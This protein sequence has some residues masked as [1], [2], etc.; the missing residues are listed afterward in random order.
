MNKLNEWIEHLNKCSETICL[1][2]KMIGTTTWPMLSSSTTTQSN[3]LQ[4]STGLFPFQLLHGQNPETPASLVSFQQSSHTQVPTAQNLIDKMDF[5]L[6][7]VTTNLLKAQQHQA[8]YADKKHCDVTYTIGDM[9]LLKA[10]NIKAQ[11]QVNR[12]SAKFQ[13]KYL[14]PFEITEQVS[15]YSYVSIYQQ[16]CVYIQYSMCHN[17]RPGTSHPLT[18]AEFRHPQHQLWL[19]TI[20]SMKSRKS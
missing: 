12:Q 11:S 1:M 8:K 20:S 3:H 9:V 13:P 16:P 2:S 6:K 10:D 17:S 5:F 18:L 14:G 4:S 15:T 7:I 19:K